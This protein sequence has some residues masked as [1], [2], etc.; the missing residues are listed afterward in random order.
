MAQLFLRSYPFIGVATTIWCFYAVSTSP[1][2]HVEIFSTTVRPING[3]LQVIQ[4]DPNIHITAPD[5]SII[6][7]CKRVV[8]QPKRLQVD[9]Y[10]MSMS[11]P[12]LLTCS[13]GAAFCIMTNRDIISSNILFTMD[14]Y[15]PEFS[16][17]RNMNLYMWELVFWA[18]VSL[19]HVAFVLSLTSPVDIF[20][21]L[22]ILSFS[23]FCLMFLC[24]PRK[25]EDSIAN[26]FRSMV[27]A[28]LLVSTW[29]TFTSIPHIY[30][31]DRLWFFACMLGLDIF[32]LVIH[33]YDSI[34]TMYTISMG[35]LT[36]V[37]LM[38]SIMAYAFMQLKDR[39][40]HVVR[41]PYESPI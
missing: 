8:D 10:H 34:P 19:S 6:P 14:T 35:R 4:C 11:I 17:T 7:H 36:I 25:A 38:N 3:T 20:D 30:E 5:G 37:A 23:I 40:E 24:R 13:C 39:L 1:P 22:V 27:I 2:L 31:E 12:F 15:D 26:T 28:T 21:M 16:V 9:V 41:L 33:L 32:L 18:Y 29:L